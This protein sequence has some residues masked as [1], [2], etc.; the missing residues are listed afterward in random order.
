MAGNAWLSRAETALVNISNVHNGVYH[1]VCRDVFHGVCRDAYA[2][3]CFSMVCGG[4]VYPGNNDYEPDNSNH[5]GI[6]V[7]LGKKCNRNL[8]QVRNWSH[9]GD[10]LPERCQRRLTG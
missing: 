8:W 9:D 10:D 7:H 1:D 3:A 6:G 4:R 2:Y 5:P